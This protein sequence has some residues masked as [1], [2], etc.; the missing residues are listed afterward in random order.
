[1]PTNTT[2]RQL[3]DAAHAAYLRSLDHQRRAIALED[4]AR[5]ILAREQPA[6]LPALGVA[7]QVLQESQDHVTITS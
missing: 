5:Q 1:M 6:T 3:L 4:Q 7:V 2:V